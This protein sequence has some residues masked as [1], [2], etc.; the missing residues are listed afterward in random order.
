MKIVLDT[1]VFISGLFFS[2]PPYEILRLWRDAKIDLVIST[3][4]L[5]EYQRVADELAVQFP[6]TDISDLLDLLMVNAEIVNAPV[7]PN[8]VCTDPED[9]KFL[10]CAA[11]SNTKYIVSGDKQL[12]KVKRYKA[13]NIINPREFI[14]TFRG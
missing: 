10:A 2:G 9:D 3:E 7:L 12:L 6:G 8:Q 5:D 4:I 14:D 13:V 11:A 1:N